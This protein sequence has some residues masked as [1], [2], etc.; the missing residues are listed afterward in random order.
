MTDRADPGP[1]SPWLAAMPVSAQGALNRL[2]KIARV[3][4]NSRVLELGCADGEVT[5]QLARH[6]GCRVVAADEDAP[7]GLPE[8]LHARGLS[9][10]VEFR[11]IERSDM[12]F[13]E[14][15]FDLIVLCRSLLFSLP[16]AAAVLRPLLAAEG[17]LVIGHRTRVGRLLDGDTGEELPAPRQLLHLLA[18][19]GFEPE[20]LET[21]GEKAG[22]SCALLVGRRKEPS[23]AP[24]FSRR[25]R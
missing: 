13:T 24:S 7:A 15:S 16:R 10:R 22:I 21:F 11:Q 14:G 5:L 17:R 23:E 20:G 6:F 25:G 19:E 4:K 9:S 3:G 2:L 8:K 18:S 1:L 12:P